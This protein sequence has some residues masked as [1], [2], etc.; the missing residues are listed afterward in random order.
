M[1]A[2]LGRN[3]SSPLSPARHQGNVKGIGSS[4]G[5][6]RPAPSLA[7]D[8]ASGSLSF[9]PCFDDDAAVS[10][11][12]HSKRKRRRPTP[13]APKATAGIPEPPSADGPPS[14]S[15]ASSAALVAFLLCLWGQ[16]LLLFDFVTTLRFAADLWIFRKRDWRK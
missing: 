1:R 7:V 8:V 12:R 9:A 2:A 6:P 13:V 16:S 15:L 5:R 3:P 10:A 4:N 14:V 11:N